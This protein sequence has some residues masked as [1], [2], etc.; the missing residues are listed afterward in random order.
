M[1]RHT[2]IVYGKGTKVVFKGGIVQNGYKLLREKYKLVGSRIPFV[3]DTWA[4]FVD[5]NT[6][7]LLDAPHL[8]FSMTLEYEH[9]SLL[10]KSK[11]RDQ[12]EEEQ[13]RR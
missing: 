8:S 13:E 4:K 9:N 5:G 3:G 6:E 10:N 1:G 2:L 12:Q 11:D 7:I